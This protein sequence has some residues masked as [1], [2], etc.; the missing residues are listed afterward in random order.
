MRAHHVFFHFHIFTAFT[1]DDA[2]F[3]RSDRKQSDNYKLIDNL[4]ETSFL[5]GSYIL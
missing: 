2:D 1:H 5:I 4:N 3:G